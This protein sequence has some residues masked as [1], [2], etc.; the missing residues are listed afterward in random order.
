MHRKLAAILGA[1]VVAY[2]KHMSLDEERTL[3]ALHQVLGAFELFARQHGGRPFGRAG[4]SILAV[5]ES[6]VE[7]VRCAAELQRHLAQQRITPTAAGPLE[8]RMAVNL[9]DVIE[10]EGNVYGDGVNTAARLQGLAGAGG[11]VVSRSA[12]EHLQG[13]ID[14]RFEHMGAHKLHNLASRV[15]AYRADIGTGSKPGW[16]RS[17]RSFAVAAGVLLVAALAGGVYLAYPRPPATQLGTLQEMA[18]ALPATPSIAVMPFANLSDNPEYLYLA[19]GL[20]DD[21]ITDLARIS[22]LF[23]IAY[24]SVGNYRGREDAVRNAGRELGVRY[25]MQG[26]LRR[27]DQKLRVNVALIDTTTGGHLWADRYDTG[28]EE[29]FSL[30]DDIVNSIASKLALKVTAS[31]QASIDERETT[32]IAAYD[33]YRRG[34]ANALRKTPDGLAEALKLFRQA[35]TI[36]P[37]YARAQAALGLVYWNAWIWGWESSVGETWETAPTRAEE[38][39]KLA[40]RRPTATAYQLASQINL[41]ARK[42]DEARRFA[43][44]AVDLDPKDPSSQVALAE[45]KIYSGEPEQSLAPLQTAMRLDPLYPPYTQFVHGLAEFGLEHYDSAAELLQRALARNPEDF[46][47]A[48]PLAALY[49]HLGQEDK[50]KEALASYRAG[51][52]EANIEEFATY[53]PYERKVDLDRIAGPLRSLGVPETLP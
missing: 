14:L 2:S 32:S 37:D 13:K 26:S 15:H 30:E 43:E 27:F 49:V 20:T 42:Y 51:W 45:V 52:P 4:D 46:S 10:D 23:V 36:D 17:H 34:W 25:V 40:L 48:A 53:W 16:L 5:F 31:Q 28:Y 39:A 18:P 11:L 47:P 6:P 21:L 7:A 3:A 44:L 41:Y 19:D 1:D 24:N 38:H 8:L 9:G 22:D 12:Y 33:A 35:V 29:L 50:A